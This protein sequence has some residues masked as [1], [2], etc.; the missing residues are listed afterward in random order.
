MALYAHKPF[1]VEAVQWNGNNASELEVLAEGTTK[2]NYNEREFYIETPNYGIIA[3]L[4]D[5]VIKDKV[6]NE[7]MLLTDEQFKANFDEVVSNEK[8]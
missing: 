7:Y 6:H 4:G 5:W 3:T 8:E 2:T 1:Y